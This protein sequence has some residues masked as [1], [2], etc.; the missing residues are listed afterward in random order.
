MPTIDWDTEELEEVTTNPSPGRPFSFNP[1]DADIV[2]VSSDNQ[3]FPVHRSALSLA[4]VVFKQMFS[5]P[6]PAP[7]SSASSHSSAQDFHDGRP[8]VRLSEDQRA[9]EILFKLI[10]QVIQLLQL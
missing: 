9:L 8:I 6:T 1:A 2:V 10:Y 5:A 4:S 7:S 3:M